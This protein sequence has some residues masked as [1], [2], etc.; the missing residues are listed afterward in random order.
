MSAIHT[1]LVRFLPEKDSILQIGCGSGRDASFMLEYL[2]E[3]ASP[4]QDLVVPDGILFE[5]V[6]TGEPEFRRIA[7]SY[8]DPAV[9]AASVPLIEY[10][11][12]AWLL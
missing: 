3:F 5:F 6:L 12:S 4:V 10:F 8:H 9:G 7:A 11:E 2:F 1:L